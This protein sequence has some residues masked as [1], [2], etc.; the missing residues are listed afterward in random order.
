MF[1]EEDAGLQLCV[2]GQ[3]RPQ[4]PGKEAAGQ[5]VPRNPVGGW[6]ALSCWYLVS[7]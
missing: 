6:R 4:D 5:A 2:L 7:T 1:G 3:G